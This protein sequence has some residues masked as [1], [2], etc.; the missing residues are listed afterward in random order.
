MTSSAN[1]RFNTRVLVGTAMLSAVAFV[2]Q[3]IEIS[4]PIMPAL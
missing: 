1:K 4:I 2:L 3:Y